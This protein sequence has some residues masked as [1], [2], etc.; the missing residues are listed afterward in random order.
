LLKNAEEVEELSARLTYLCQLIQKDRRPF[1]PVNGVLLL[2]P[3]ASLA[4]EGEAHQ[5]GRIC[6]R[7]L[8]T[9]QEALQ[10]QCPVFALVCDLE[11]VDGCVEIITRLPERQRLFRLGLSFPLAPDLEAAQIPGMVEDG[12]RWVC[13][14]QVPTLIYRLL[15]IEPGAVQEPALLTGNIRM[16][17]LLY[18][19][20]ERQSRLGRLLSRSVLRP[21]LALGG[22]FFAS[23]GADAATEQAFVAGVLPLLVQSQNAVAWTPQLLAEEATFRRWTWRGYVGLSLLS[24]ALLALVW[25]L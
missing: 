9:L 7:D 13:E 12:V 25:L 2:L 11:R 18:E 20:R 16:Y 22:C 5:M 14:T 15:R 4:S 23:S 21:S 17:Q 1:C 8:T 19:L 6:Q 3:W 24:V 10:V